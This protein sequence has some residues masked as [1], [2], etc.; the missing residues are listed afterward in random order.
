[1]QIKIISNKNPLFRQFEQNRKC[2]YIF[3][4]N[5][6]LD[7]F[8]YN[9]GKSITFKG[10]V[11]APLSSKIAE[12]AKG[13]MIPECIKATTSKVANL[14]QI[15]YESVANKLNGQLAYFR[16]N[17]IE[18]IINSFAPKDKELAT[19]SLAHMS[20]WGN[21]E[22][23]NSLAS[24]LSKENRTLYSENKTCLANSIGYLKDKGSFN[25]LIFKNIDDYTEIKDK[26]MI[27]I[28]EFVLNRLSKDKKLVDFIKQNPDIQLCYPDGWIHGINPFNQTSTDE[29]GGIVKS[30]V[31]KAKILLTKNGANPDEIISN[32]LNEAVISQ[33]EELGLKDRLK[34]IS[35]C[36][37]NKDGILLED[38][39][40]Q[41]EHKG[42]SA[43][44]L[45]KQI[46]AELPEEYRPLML[47]A[48]NSEAKI[49]DSRRISLMMQE[50]YR[51]ILDIA[52]QKNIAPQDISYFVHKS[53]K[54]YGM[55]A[56][57]YQATN[58]I[59]P[60]KFIENIKDLQSGNLVVILDDYAGSG[61]SL[62][63][64]AIEA[65]KGAGYIVLS[66]MFS[67]QHAIDRLKKLD[68]P[69]DCI[70]VNVVP[71]KTVESIK[72]SNF[73]NSQSRD[74]KL[75]LDRA[76]VGEGGI[77]ADTSIAFPHMA[78]DN[79]HTF[80]NELIAPQYLLNGNGAKFDTYHW[81]DIKKNILTGTLF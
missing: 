25:N 74:K 32:V 45:Q 11:P 20:Q 31:Q 7:S 56:Q 70:N 41:F 78:P 66:P 4:S 29:T 9:N 47:E 57:Q 76:F 37:I 80:F 64:A 14:G 36:K 44:Y 22:S 38:I 15:T 19:L 17:D 1:M 68:C 26:G 53:G 61:A 63:V 49:L 27:L 21:F 71:F 40:K 13:Q 33:L 81:A 30:V 55:I 59:S 34:I 67:T 10:N 18:K 72:C 54:S 35:G 3:N 65:S 39:A 75:L 62:N 46:E 50:Q 16:K 73:Y 52:K 60:N 77:N 5:N 24:N 12:L 28:D 6:L 48:I 43:E 58:K 51:K 42:I 79:N 69:E 8:T 2:S 23:L